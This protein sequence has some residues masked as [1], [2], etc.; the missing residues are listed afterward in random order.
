MD[1]RRF[2]EK[3]RTYLWCGGFGA[4][5]KSFERGVTEGDL[6]VIAGSRLYAYIVYPRRFRPSEVCWTFEKPTIERIIAFQ[7]HVFGITRWQ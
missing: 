7:K 3:G 1:N 2:D 4:V 5:V 6:R